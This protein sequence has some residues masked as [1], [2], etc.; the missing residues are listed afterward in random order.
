MS[1]AS[2]IFQTKDIRTEVKGIFRLPS[3]WVGRFARHE[4]YKRSWRRRMEK[5][6]GRSWTIKMPREDGPKASSKVWKETE[7]E[8][9][10]N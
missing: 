8:D 2:H 7:A 6:G 5:L 9:N 3:S 1:K 4:A 10:S